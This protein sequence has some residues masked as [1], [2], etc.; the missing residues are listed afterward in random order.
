[1]RVRA[2]YVSIT[3]A[4][5]ILGVSERTVKRYINAGHLDAGTLPSGIT[6]LS[7]AQVLGLVKPST[8]K[9]A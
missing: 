6:R 8:R 2:V 7:R 4:A 9:T 3:D 1:M 5:V